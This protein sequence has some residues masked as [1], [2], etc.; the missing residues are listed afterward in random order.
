MFLAPSWNIRHNKACSGN[1]VSRHERMDRET[2]GTRSQY[3]RLFS[4]GFH[5]VLDRFDKSMQI[6]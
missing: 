2:S 5:R 3:R 6:I 4:R 1:G